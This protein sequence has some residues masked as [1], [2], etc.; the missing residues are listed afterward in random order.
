ME[1][2]MVRPA[3]VEHELMTDGYFNVEDSFNVHIYKSKFLD[4]LLRAQTGRMSL[5]GIEQIDCLEMSFG[6]VLRMGAYGRKEVC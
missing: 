3:G 1:S 2:G 4:R 6:E 5:N